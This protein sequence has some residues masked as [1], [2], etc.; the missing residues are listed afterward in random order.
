[1]VKRK[2]SYLLKRRRRNDDQC[3]FCNEEDTPEHI[4]FKCG[5]LELMRASLVQTGLFTP[6]FIFDLIML[7]PENWRRFSEV[8]VS[9]IR[10]KLRIS[11]RW[12]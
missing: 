7:S 8:V 5:Q 6:E 1:M 3:L 12:R 4:I 2:Y 11:G 10:K 9:I